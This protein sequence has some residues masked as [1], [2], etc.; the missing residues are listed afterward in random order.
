MRSG[1][2]KS[3]WLMTL[4]PYIPDLLSYL[5]AVMESLETDLALILILNIP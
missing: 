2:E 4:R 5:G 1:R 3:A